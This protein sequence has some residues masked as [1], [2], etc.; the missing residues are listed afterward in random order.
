MPNYR[1]L[2]THIFPYKD[3]IYDRRKPVFLNILRSQNLTLRNTSE[4]LVSNK[5]IDVSLHFSDFPVSFPYY[6]INIF[7]YVFIDLLWYSS[8]LGK[9]VEKPWYQDPTVSV[10]NYGIFLYQKLLMRSFILAGRTLPRRVLRSRNIFFNLKK[11]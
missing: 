7:Y 8:I 9:T 10:L 3:R 2:L 5:N 4:Q 1:F 11:L 6:L